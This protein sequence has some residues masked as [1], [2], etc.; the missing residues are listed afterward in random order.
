MSTPRNSSASLLCCL[1]IALIACTAIPAFAAPPIP[2]AIFT[3]SSGCI[4]VD[5]NIYQLKTDVFLDGGPA[6]PGAASLPDGAYYV[7]VTDPSGATVLGTSVGLPVGVGSTFDKPFVVTGGTVACFEI[8]LNVINPS[9]GNAQGYADTPNPGDEYKVWVSNDPTFVNNS[10][11]TDNFKVLT[12]GSVN[13]P[14]TSFTISGKKFYD[15]SLN[16]DATQPGIAGWIVSIFDATNSG[17]FTSYSTTTDAS[18]NYSFINLPAGSYGIC[19][20][21]PSASPVWIPTYPTPI[22]PGTPFIYDPITLGPDSANNNFGNV[23][24]GAGGGLTLGFW[25]NKNGQNLII[26]SDLCFLNTLNLVNGNGSAFDPQ[27]NCPSPTSTQLATAKTNLKNWLLSATATN[28]AYMLSA[29]LTAMELNVIHGFV[30]GSDLV[31]APGDPHAS[32]AGLVSITTLMAD[33]NT[34]LGSNPNTPSGNSA[35]SYQEGLKNALDSANN[36]LNF[37][38]GS[39]CAVNY[40]AQDVSCTPY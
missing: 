10:T 22:K 37:V 32:A 9:A 5:G 12:N 24:L 18:G 35:R 21:I 6:H 11:K 15:A 36:N 26:A 7:Q 34:S 4:Q 40:T 38:Q 27:A 28:M 30:N 13:P 8:W 3:T 2:G 31:Y 19:E 14:P 29:Q 23:C 1:A 20:L 39:A 33:A 16:G 25:S 17:T